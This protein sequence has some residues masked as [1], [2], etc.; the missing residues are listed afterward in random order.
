M[1]FYVLTYESST[2]IQTSD[3][4]LQYVNV[5][6]IGHWYDPIWVGVG[7]KKLDREARDKRKGNH[8]IFHWFHYEVI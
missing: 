7:L 5:Q 2:L 6:N 3:K 8:C 1:H 4:T